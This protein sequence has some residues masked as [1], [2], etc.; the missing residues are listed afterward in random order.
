MH[1]PWFVYAFA[2]LLLYCPEI[3]LVSLVV[4][5]EVCC[6][7]ITENAAALL[8][9]VTHSTLPALLVLFDATCLWLRWGTGRTVQAFMHFVW[10]Q[11][12]YPV[13][14]KYDGLSV[15]TVRPWAVAPRGRWCCR[16]SVFRCFRRNGDDGSCSTGSGED[17]KVKIGNILLQMR[18]ETEGGWG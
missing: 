5:V 16:C 14:E 17:W 13:W 9:T 12:L 10:A 8:W 7:T 15:V 1:F 3:V 11:G 18:A 2:I 4:L 6:V